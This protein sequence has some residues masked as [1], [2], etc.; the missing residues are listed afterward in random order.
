MITLNLTKD[1]T[2]ALLA[3]M[4]AGV[5]A[6]GRPAARA[7]PVLDDKIQ[8][9]MWSAEARPESERDQRL[10]TRDWGS[11]LSAPEKP[12]SGL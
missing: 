9:A 10:G 4:D 3:L 1:E 2:A 8:A 11:Q 7:C 6:V 5:K 12:T